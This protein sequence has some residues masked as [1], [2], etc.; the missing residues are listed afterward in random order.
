MSEQFPILL[1]R[2][3]ASLLTGLDEKYFDRLRRENKLRTYK[4]LGGTHRFFR[5]E[6]LKHIG[7]E[8]TPNNQTPQ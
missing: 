6:V 8:F 5:A 1:N 3:Q 2:K 7:V 4:T